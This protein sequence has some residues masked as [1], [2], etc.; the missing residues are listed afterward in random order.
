LKYL[1]EKILPVAEEIFK[2]KNVAAIGHRGSLT[3]PTRKATP[4]S[5]I[6]LFILLDDSHS[7]LII[8]KLKKVPGNVSVINMFET[9]IKKG[10]HKVSFDL[11]PADKFIKTYKKRFNKIDYYTYFFEFMDVIMTKK[12]FHY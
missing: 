1:N 3:I 7:E 9:N 2:L 10:E 5:D 8:K 11:I 12:R 6:D 4:L